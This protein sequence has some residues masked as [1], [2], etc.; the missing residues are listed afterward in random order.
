[1]VAMVARRRGGSGGPQTRTP[2][3]WM[4]TQGVMQLKAMTRREGRSA[5]IRWRQIQAPPPGP[6]LEAALEASG[7]GAAQWRLLAALGPAV[8]ADGAERLLVWLALPSAER[9]LCGRD[10]KGWL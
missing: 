5:D 10:A 7:H 2:A 9:E 4:R 8:A 3:K 1:M 6:P